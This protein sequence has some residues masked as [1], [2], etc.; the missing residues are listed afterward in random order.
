MFEEDEALCPRTAGSDI[1]G[2]L[3]FL[4]WDWLHFFLSIDF[5]IWVVL[6]RVFPMLF[7]IVFAFWFYLFYLLAI[8]YLDFTGI[9][10]TLI[11]DSFILLMVSC[12]FWQ[13]FFWTSFYNYIIFLSLSFNYF[14]YALFIV[15]IFYSFLCSYWIFASFSRSF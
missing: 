8:N 11:D 1:F 5:L 7:P 15:V 10:F 6:P 9:S 4:P 14:W 12:W 13:K 2:A 3:F